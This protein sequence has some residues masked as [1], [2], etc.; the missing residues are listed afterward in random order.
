MR[1]LLSRNSD[2]FHDSPAIFA[3]WP[4]GG[5]TY[6]VGDRLMGF[7]DLEYKSR[8]KLY[9]TRPVLRRC[10]KRVP[11]IGIHRR[12]PDWQR[13]KV[14]NLTPLNLPQAGLFWET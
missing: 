11:E 12:I 9:V 2:G 8:R 3:R 5:V 4:K 13:G 6:N 10:K 1:A 7:S 14:H